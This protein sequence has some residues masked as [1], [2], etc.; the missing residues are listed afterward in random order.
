M[1]YRFKETKKQNIKR[2]RLLVKSVG[3]LGTSKINIALL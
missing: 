1:S 2:G 3:F